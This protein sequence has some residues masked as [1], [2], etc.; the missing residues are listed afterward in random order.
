MTPTKEQIEARARELWR[1]E[2]VSN[3]CIEALEINPELDELKESGYYWLAQ[4]ELMRNTDN[5]RLFLEQETNETQQ[6]YI[7]LKTLIEE[8]IKYGDLLAI[9]NKGYGKTHALMNLARTFMQTPNT[10]VIIFETFPK[11]IHEFD[12]IPYLYIEDCDVIED[13][14]AIQLSEEDYFV[15]TSRDYSILNGNT[16][17]NH[18]ENCEDLLFTIAIEDTDRLSFFISSVIYYFYRKH[19]LTAYKYGLDAI[20]ERVVFVCEESQNLFDSSIIS[21]RIFNK[22]RKMY[23]ET[24]NLKI[25]FVMAS[26]RIQDL[27]TKIR[28]RTKYL[29]GN[30]NIDDWQ[31]KVN[32]ILKNSEYRNDVLKFPIGKFLYTPTDR[33]IQFSKFQQYGKPYS[34]EKLLESLK[35]Q[36]TP[37]PSIWQKL[38]DIF[39]LHPYSSVRY[40]C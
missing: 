2:Q 21:K 30:V 40:D 26:Q 19:Y 36:P 34:F 15:R 12:A 10:K 1:S 14:S 9:A 13:Y 23:S 38:R 20:E 16:I 31:L 4:N 7:Q 39:G 33:T 25:H 18:L 6:K 37:K 8:I 11:W 3:G 28:G 24:R 22:L 17:E 5:Y 27:N 32:R 29:I 35:P